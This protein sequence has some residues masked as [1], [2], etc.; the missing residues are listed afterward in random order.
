MFVNPKYDPN[1]KRSIQ[2]WTTDAIDDNQDDGTMRRRIVGYYNNIWGS[3]IAVT[4]VDYDENDVETTADLRVKRVYTIEVLRRIDGPS[5]TVASIIPK[6]GTTS[7]ITIEAPYDQS[8]APVTGNFYIACPNDD[9][10]EFRTRDMGYGWGASSIDFYLQLEIPHL[11]F[12]T[13]V[14]DTGKYDYR[15]NGIALQIVMQDYHGDVP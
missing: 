5:F 7:T 15:N 12:K 4:H 2:L 6:S 3:N 10:S 11:Q 1:N 13:M 14:R 8:S 9:G